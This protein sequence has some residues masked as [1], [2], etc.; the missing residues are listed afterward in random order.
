MDKQLITTSALFRL[1][2]LVL[3]ERLLLHLFGRRI[4]VRRDRLR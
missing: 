2:R 4:A 1:V 3:P